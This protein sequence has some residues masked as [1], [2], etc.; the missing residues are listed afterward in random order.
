MENQNS[1]DDDDDEI[2]HYSVMFGNIDNESKI[3]YV[4]DEIELLKS[5]IINIKIFSNMYEGKEII[6]GIEYTF[7]NLNTGKTQ[8]ILHRGSYNFINVK[9]FRINN[10]EYLTD[11]YIR[12]KN[13]AEYISQLGFSTNL[14]RTIIVGNEEGELKIIDSNGGNNIIIGIFGAVNKKLDSLRILYISKK[15]YVKYYIFPF[16]FLRYRIKNNENFIKEW[17]QRYKELPIE[18]QYIWKM[19]NLEDD[20]LL[21]LIFKFCYFYI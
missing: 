21:Y 18:D 1:I 20:N 16:L 2:I 8:N 9:E 10:N 13:E 7:K 4:N 5:R 11:F 14:K 15:N 3:W 17:E 6:N 19:V 12:F